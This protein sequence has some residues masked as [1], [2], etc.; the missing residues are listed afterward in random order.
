[1]SR[2]IS[3]LDEKQLKY[4]HTQ[5]VTRTHAEGN[6]LTGRHICADVAILL[7]PHQEVGSPARMP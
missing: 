5:N 4:V 7:Q 3:S 2:K 1:M 6:I